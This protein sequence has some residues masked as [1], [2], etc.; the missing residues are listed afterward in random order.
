M[1]INRRSARSEVSGII[2]DAQGLCTAAVYKPRDCASRDDDLALQHV[3]QLLG[4]KLS[5]IERGRVADLTEVSASETFC[6][7]TLSSARTQRVIRAHRNMSFALGQLRGLVLRE[8]V[9]HWSVAIPSEKTLVAEIAN[10]N[11]HSCCRNRGASI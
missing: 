5:A 10:Q 2:E 8:P 7:D 11:W 3:C 9:Q 1:V 4:R 6:Q